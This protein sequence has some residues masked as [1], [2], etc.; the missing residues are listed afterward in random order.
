[1]T[2]TTPLALPLARTTLALLAVAAL[3]ALA[4][5]QANRAPVGVDD[6]FG[7]IP[8][9]IGPTCIP[10]ANFLLNDTDPDGD[11]LT[12]VDFDFAGFPG[13]IEADAGGTVCF[14]TA[15]DFSGVATFTYRPSDGRLE[16]A[17]TTVA[18]L[19]EAAGETTVSLS[20][21]YVLVP[22]EAPGLTLQP[23]NS[24]NRSAAIAAP[25][26]P[27]PAL[28][29][30]RLTDLGGGVHELVSASAGR[31]LEAYDVTPANGDPVNIY[32]PNRR[33]W[34]RWEIKRNTDATFRLINEYNPRFLDLDGDDRARVTEALA[35][36][37]WR[38]VPLAE[39]TCEAPTPPTPSLAGD[40][41]IH[42]PGDPRG[43]I[44]PLGSTNRSSVTVGDCDD[45]AFTWTA[46][47]L[48]DGYH[49]FVNTSARRALESYDPTPAPGDAVTVYRLN[50]QAWQQ[51]LLERAGDDT[52]VVSN[53]NN[54]LP[55]VELAGGGRLRVGN[56]P[57]DL[58][59]TQ[60]WVITE[61]RDYTCPADLSRLGPGVP[62]ADVNVAAA[63]VRVYPTTT[64]GTLTAAAAAPMRHL[65]VVNATGQQIRRYDADGAQV[66]E[67]DVADLPA[68]AYWL[69]VET[70][71][72]TSAH[73]FQRLR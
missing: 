71:E 5:A 53:R 41:V 14:T 69:H 45:G 4:L 16:G 12:A 25:C 51:W 10:A 54:P 46:T 24:P 20:G 27:D 32:S 13:E 21:D 56:D 15:Q 31:A 39:Y 11:A 28:Y 40:Y 8:E 73:A 38:I 55:L 61:A 65:T 42:R 29:T 22:R 36:S 62:S 60:Q 7:D 26:T 63:G 67:I 19:V 66:R 68:G 49:V 44:R 52:Y 43:V 1:M 47:D 23:R 50:G 9:D 72:G 37:R 3:P 35:S 64:V 2:L 57:S 48:G 58:L 6:E 34:Q 70:A 30:W 59:A 33:P 18:I 17:P